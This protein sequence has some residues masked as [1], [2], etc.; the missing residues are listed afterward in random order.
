M[1]RRP[2]SRSNR[3]IVERSVFSGRIPMAALVQTRA[4]AEYLSFHCAAAAL[5]ISQS[6][7]SARVKALEEELGILLFERNTRGVRLTDAGHQFVSEIDAAFE[8]LDRAIKTAGMHARGEQGTLRVGVYALVSGGPL[9]VLLERFRRSYAD[10]TLDI[11]ETSAREA[12]V[13]VRDG[14]LDVAFMPYANEVSDLHSRLLWRDRLMVA[15]PETHPLAK[16]QHV[17]WSQL[18]DENFLVRRG[19]AGPQVHD[20]ILDRSAGRRPVPNIIRFDVGRDTLLSMIAAGYG[21]SVFVE[22]N[23]TTIARNV[24]FVPI[25]DEPESAPFSAV[26]SPK[27]S[28]P[29]LRK[30]FTLAADIL[31]IPQS[32]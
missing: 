24:A 2:Y 31:R 12:Q 27:N 4:V 25:S 13:Q 22:E 9:D 21:I 7:V 15:L 30:L 17:E 23:A 3:E 6:S 26:W 11:A 1:R 20:L 29:A 28:K 5:G 19:G 14:H 10:V 32:T 18:A 8:I 16:M